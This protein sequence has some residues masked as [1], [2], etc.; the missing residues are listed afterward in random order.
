MSTMSIIKSPRAQWYITDNRHTK[1][2]ELVEQ[3][4]SASPNDGITEEPENSMQMTAQI[5]EK[6]H[7]LEGKPPI[8]YV[9]VHNSSS[10]TRLLEEDG[11]VV[12]EGHEAA[13]NNN[14]SQNVAD[15]NA[16]VYSD[17]QD[18]RTSSSNQTRPE[19]PVPYTRHR[20]KTALTTLISIAWWQWRCQGNLCYV[21]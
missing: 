11:V 21:I 18:I 9:E 5:S 14:E 20:S 19:R 4:W 16:V 8:V 7:D 1:S 10:T 15:N 2:I 3:Q 17:L 13:N 6:Y 12:G